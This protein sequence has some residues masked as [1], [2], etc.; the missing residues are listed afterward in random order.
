MIV[1]YQGRR[2]CGKTLSMVK[3]MVQY[4]I[5]GLTIYR[6]FK[7]SIG[8]PISN[9]A[10]MNLSKSSRIKDCVLAIDEIQIFFD[11]RRSMKTKNMRFSNFIQ[12]IRK[13][14]IILLATT[15]YI[16]TVDMRFRQHVDIVAS[17]NFKKNFD[18]CE[19]T[20]TDMTSLEDLNINDNKLD[21][22]KLV[23]DA[24]PIYKLFD[25]EQMIR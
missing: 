22:V 5:D 10:I 12:Q 9:T 4:Q 21:S 19:I 17:P 6:N 13:R 25:T 16:G 2:G 24:K 20:Y 15:Q 23:F 18:C 8:K 11:S 3:D 1:S 7:C 14:N